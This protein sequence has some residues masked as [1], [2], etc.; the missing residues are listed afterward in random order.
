MAGTESLLFRRPDSPRDSPVSLSSDILDGSDASAGS[1]ELA[2]HVF[3]PPRARSSKSNTA[4]ASSVLPSSPKPARATCA[5]MSPMGAHVCVFMCRLFRLSNSEVSQGVCHL[6][7]V[8]FFSSSVS[9]G[10]YY[11]LRHFHKRGFSAA[12]AWL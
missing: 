7:L 12:P 10:T 4:R 11:S 2:R 9:S 3:R 6:K 1:S 8:F 5:H